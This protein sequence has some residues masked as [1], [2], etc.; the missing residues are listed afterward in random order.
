M[1]L[2][3]NEQKSLQFPT[4]CNSHCL[5]KQV[6]GTLLWLPLLSL[7]AWNTVLRGCGARSYLEWTAPKRPRNQLEWYFQASWGLAA[8]GILLSSWRVGWNL[9]LRVPSGRR[10]YWRKHF[11]FICRISSRLCRGKLQNI[12]TIS[13]N[14][15]SPYSIIFFIKKY[16]CSFSHLSLLWKWSLK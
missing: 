3:W 10:V 16:S 1:I 11:Y 8:V 9:G 5:L 6:Q 7:Q 4:N 14:S 13:R 15:L 2:G 12:L